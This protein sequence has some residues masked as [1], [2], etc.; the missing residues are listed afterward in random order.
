MLLINNDDVKKVLTM[1]DTIDALEDAYTQ[2]VKHESVCRPRIDIQIPTTDPN[3]VYRWGTMEGGSM[4]GYFAIR[5]KSDIL[6]ETEYQGAITQEKYCQKPGTF[7][8][9]IIL[10]SV[11][12][13]EPLAIINDGELQHMR[14][15]ADGGLGV[16]YAARD[17]CEVIGML[18]SGGQSRS[19]MAS[20]MH[21]RPG[22]RRLQVFSP[23]RANCEAFAE[24]VR[25]KYRIEVVVCDKPEQIYDDADIVAALTDSAVPVIDPQHIKPGD[26]VI[27]IGGGGYIGGGG[28]P[29]NTLLDRIDLYLRFGSTLAPWGRP[30]FGVSDEFLTYAAEP[31]SIPNPKMK[32]IGKRGHGALPVDNTVTFSDIVNKGLKSARSDDKQI[33]Y[34][35]RGNLQGQQF[36][37]VGGVAYEKAKDHGL[38]QEL[39]TEWLLQNIRN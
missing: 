9:F 28:T 10:M 18:G 16:K 30:E 11:D 37:S 13:G 12:S 20:F 19:H 5:I 29:G 26:H 4:H 6:Y 1:G 22:L 15:G 7:C 2:H 8:G 17:N 31:A 24:E 32:H 39:P 21:V 34:S 35:E 36:W 27:N 38:G 14:V 33:S 3:K 23:T 25:E